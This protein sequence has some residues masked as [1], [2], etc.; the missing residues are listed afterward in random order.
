MLVCAYVSLSVSVLC[1][2]TCEFVCCKYKC[3]RVCFR[4]WAG[5][6]DAGGGDDGGGMGSCEVGCGVRG[7][8]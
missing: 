8:G 7:G 6:M 1:A 2:H 5:N 4:M 3:A